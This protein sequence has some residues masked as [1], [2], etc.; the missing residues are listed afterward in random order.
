MEGCE[1]LRVGISDES[2]CVV[3][4][5][6]GGC[7]CGTGVV[8]GDRSLHSE[9]KLFKPVGCAPLEIRCCVGEIAVM[10]IPLF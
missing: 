8:G 9:D 4:V 2:V 7:G 1:V 6:I 5:D 10:P 3:T